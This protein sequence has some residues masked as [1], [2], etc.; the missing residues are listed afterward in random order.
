[1]I[2]DFESINREMNEDKIIAPDEIFRILPDTGEKY[3]YLRDVQGEVLT[4]WFD[5]DVRH[6]KDTI[7]KMNTGSGKTVVGLLMLKSCIEEG[8]GPAV[9][10]VPDGY[11]VEQVITEAQKLGIETTTDAES[12]DYLRC[13]A[14][15]VI[16]IYKL[17]N[18]KSVFGMRTRG[19]NIPIGSIVIDDVHAALLTTEQQFRICIPRSNNMYSEFLS[20]FEGS[21]R[22]QSEIKYLEIKDGYD[23]HEMLVPF[24]DWQSKISYIK[25]LF[26]DN[27]DDENIQFNWPLLKDVIEFSKCVITDKEIEITPNSIPIDMIKNF[28]NAKRRIFMSA[29]LSDDTPFLTHFGVNFSKA[30]II[31]PDSANDMGERLILV[32]QAINSSVDDN[33]LRNEIMKISEKHNVVVIVPSNRIAEEWP[34]HQSRIIDKDNINKAVNALKKKH[35]GI[36]I[37]V[38]RYD[39]VDLPHNACRLLV[40]DGLPDVRS[41][42]DLIEEGALNRSKRIQNQFIQ[43]IEQGMGRGVRSNTDYCAVLLMGKRLIGTIYADGAKKLFSS[44]TLKQF[45]L[46][47]IISDKIRGASI[48]DIFALLD[49]TFNRDKGWIETSRKA[50]VKVRYDDIPNVLESEKV[51]REAFD[52][53]RKRNYKKSIDILNLYQ[54]TV[55]NDA[56]KGWILQRLAEYYNFID[57]LEAQNIIKTAKKHNISVLNP[58]DGILTTRE[59]N[60]Y[61]SQ[62]EQFIENNRKSKLDERIYILKVNAVL[63]GLVFKPDTSKCFEE[64]I[65]NLAL[66]I[67]FDAQRPENEVGRGPDDLWM[68]GQLEFLVIECKNGVENLII[69]KHDCDQLNGS[70]NWF[71]EEFKDKSCSMTPIMI[72]RGDT[73]EYACAPNR[74]IRIITEDKL[75]SLK[76]NVLSFAKAVVRGEFSNMSKISELLKSNRLTGNDIVSEY[77]VKFKKKRFKGGSA[78]R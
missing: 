14:I 56:L 69:N 36:L 52:F 78:P 1:M 51:K 58:L 39:G 11:L 45:E 76:R 9:Y 68:I 63:D 29:T 24:W 40:L 38:N 15:L 25:Q 67:G 46:S 54:N 35:I 19:D 50:L 77:S 55:E 30:K 21:L 23:Y 7:L 26:H 43:K 65:K 20:I 53:A 18:G 12:I 42:Y 62:A 37:F 60:K 48:K 75:N 64:A 72:H 3:E 66:L 33:E 44:A 2:I 17:V 70:I 27:K 8:K 5:E 59:L 47:E 49:Y 73:F 71:E 16:N 61:L 34:I 6:N 4:K 74:N 41:K 22:N 13:K 32:P 28:N 10:V 31:T 57:A